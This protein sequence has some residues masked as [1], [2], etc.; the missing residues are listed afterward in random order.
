LPGVSGLDF[1]NDVNLEHSGQ[2]VLYI[3]GFVGSV[4]VDGILHCDRAVLLAKPFTP[5]QLVS[6]VRELIG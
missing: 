2:K 5:A 1:A 3:S 4:F 6:R